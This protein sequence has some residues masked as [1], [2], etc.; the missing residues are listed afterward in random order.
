MTAARCHAATHGVL[1]GVASLLAAGCAPALVSLS[2]ARATPEGRTDVALG[3]GVRVPL[4][5]VAPPAVPGGTDEVLALLSPGGAVP[6]EALRAGVAGGWD[7]GV[8]AAGSG[9]RVELRGDHALGAMAHVHG[10]IA[11]GGG[12]ARAEPTQG[13]TGAEGYR[14]GVF[15]PVTLGIDVSSIFEAWATARLG[16]ER[17]EGT[18]GL[19]GAPRASEAWLLRA[20]LAL[21]LA[22]GFR[23]VHVLLEVGLDAEHARGTSGGVAFERT[24]GA[25]TP[26][27][28]LRVRF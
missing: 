3:T 1:L 5:D 13:T 25:V 24:G 15:V 18:V 10:G 28:G 20:G 7:L 17:V 11:L 26:A 21:G 2:G 8:V 27:V 9:G 19:G 6:V 4:A 22:V 16:A 14:L 12:Y 23:R